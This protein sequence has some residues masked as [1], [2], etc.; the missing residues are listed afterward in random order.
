[1]GEGVSVDAGLGWT[2]AGG[3][4]APGAKAINSKEI[5]QRIGKE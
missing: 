3:V 5:V 1:V 2:T 4:V